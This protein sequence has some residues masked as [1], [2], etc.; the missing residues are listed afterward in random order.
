MWSFCKVQRG[1]VSV[2]FSSCTVVHC[3]VLSSYCDYKRDVLCCSAAQI[4]SDFELFFISLFHCD[5][6]EVQVSNEFHSCFSRC[7]LVPEHHSVVSF[8]MAAENLHFVTSFCDEIR[9]RLTDLKTQTTTWI[10][11]KKRELIYIV[12]YDQLH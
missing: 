5:I 3:T 6:F 9:G 7:L 1:F 4:S 11:N 10:E 12:T 2:C 8:I